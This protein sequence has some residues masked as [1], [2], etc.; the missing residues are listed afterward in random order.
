MS[1]VLVATRIATR[2]LR[3]APVTS[4]LVIVILAVPLGLAFIVTMPLPTSGYMVAAP[5]LAWTLTTAALAGA[6]VLVVTRLAVSAL[7]RRRLR[8]GALLALNGARRRDARLL[9][10]ADAAVLVLPAT[11]VGFVAAVVYRLY[12]GLPDGTPGTFIRTLFRISASTPSGLVI[13]TAT[14]LAAL[15]AAVPTTGPS[16]ATDIRSAL[17]G[18]R[19]STPVGP[20]HLLGALGLT[21]AGLASMSSIHPGWQSLAVVLLAGAAYLGGTCLLRLSEPAGSQLGFVAALTGRSLNRQRYRTAPL[22][23]LMAVGFSIAVIPLTARATTDT[24]AATARAALD[25]YRRVMAPDRTVILQSRAYGADETSVAP[26][27]VDQVTAALPG[28][29][30]TRIPLVSGPNPYTTVQTWN[31]S[32]G[33]VGTDF[34]PGVATPEV[35]AGLGLTDHQ[36][37][38]TAGRALVLNPLAATGERNALR[39]GVDLDGSPVTLDAVDVSTGELVESLPPLLLPPTVLASGQPASAETVVIR[40]PEPIT[41][42]LDR[43][44]ELGFDVLA[45][46]GSR[47]D[48]AMTCPNDPNCH[49]ISPLTGRRL[50]VDDAARRYASMALPGA[51]PDDL[52]LAPRAAFQIEV[53]PQAT[54]AWTT[55]ALVLAAA[56]ALASVGLSVTQRRTDDALLA[57]QGSPAQW[58]RRTSALET[59]TIT[60]VAALLAAVFGPLTFWAYTVSVHRQLVWPNPPPV[61]LPWPALTFLL[62]V[63]PV[64]MA[65]LAYGLTPPLR[66]LDVSRLTDDD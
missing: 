56:I 31:P 19:P 29:K 33:P 30:A 10:L 36:D 15:L 37:D 18:R 41:G 49:V 3:R 46:T 20:L 44:H 51:T 22:A 24:A 21:G 63:V 5:D 64:A 2:E 16:P 57:L 12:L 35:L 66:R 60:A 62:L 58:R 9:R 28:S 25:P 55:L 59:G 40:S 17:A 61:A 50:V 39:V 45:G 4:G 38:V 43:L 42:G 13:V 34:L 7:A 23:A 1:R 54:R 32:V 53:S 26:G 48:S 27:L 8:T 65:L 6:I 14:I 47:P 52:S 11:A